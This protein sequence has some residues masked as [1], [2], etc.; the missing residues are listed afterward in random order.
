MLCETVAGKPVESGAARRLQII[1]GG[2]PRLLAIMA[3]FAAE[4]SF[5]A[6]MADLLD[7]VDEHTAYFK[8]HLESLPSQER[9]VYLALLETLE[10]IHGPGGG[11]A[12]QDRDE[13]VQRPAQTPDGARRGVGSGRDAQTPAVLRERAPLRHLLSAPPKQGRGRV[14]PG[15]GGVHGGVLLAAGTEGA[16]GSDGGRCL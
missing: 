4:T 15:S 9:R 2:S 10:A 13:R 6:L 3:R 14:G 1:T 12:R 8:S 5:G 7:M 11:G 16:G